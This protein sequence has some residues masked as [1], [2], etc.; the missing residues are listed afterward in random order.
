MIVTEGSDGR[1]PPPETDMST[2]TYTAYHTMD[3]LGG[4]YEQ[5]QIDYTGA[6]LATA[7]C[8]AAS[9]AAAGQG[10]GVADDQGRTL[11]PD[12]YWDAAD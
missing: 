1:C 6:D 11:G 3:Q 5:R 10:G 8:I 7:K 9:R 2:T 4:R 12:G